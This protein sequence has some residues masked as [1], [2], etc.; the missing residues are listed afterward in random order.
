MFLSQP[1]ATPLDLHF[2]LF[3]TPVRVHPLFW[4]FGAI[5]YMF[6]QPRLGDLGLGFLALWLGWMFLSILIHEFGHIT[7]ARLCG[8]RGR[9]ILH[10]MGGLAVWDAPADRRWQRIAIAA[11]G[12]GGGFLLFGLVWLIREYAFPHIPLDFLQQHPETREIITQSLDMVLFMAMLWNLL[13]LLPILPLDGGQISLEVFTGLFPKQGLRL[14]LGL[15][16]LLAGS[17]AIYC[18]RVW[19]LPYQLHPGFAAVFLGMMAFQNLQVL[20][21]AERERGKEATNEEDW[22]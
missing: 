18:L 19:K 13:N 12:P 5:F 22:P 14:A 16:I 1:N 21:Q 9:I 10:S 6:L 20:L 17:A 7:L 8:R 4:L 2:R 15:S 3:G 11:A